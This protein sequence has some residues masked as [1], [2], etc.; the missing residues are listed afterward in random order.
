[1]YPAFSA[2]AISVGSDTVDHGTNH[3]VTIGNVL[4]ASGGNGS[5]TYQ[6]RRNGTTLTGSASTSTSYNIGS[7]ASIYSTA[8]TYTFKRYAKDGL[9]NT[10][11]NESSG[12][13]TLTVKEPYVTWTNCSSSGFTM[14]SNKR[15]EE[16]RSMYWD[17]AKLLCEGIG[18]GWRLP[19]LTELQCMCDNKSSIPSRYVSGIYYW[20]SMS[21]GSG[22]YA[23]NF[24]N[25]D[26]DS[27]YGGIYTG[28]VKCV[29]N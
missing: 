5:I 27:N 1:V 10:A 28:Y 13:Y 24:Y 18:P 19:N 15:S 6:W 26:V 11:W 25:C 2:G 29:H 23:V 12:A 16:N 8:G 22:H 3:N 21:G 14:I 17:D 9:C 20:S 7:D 4:D